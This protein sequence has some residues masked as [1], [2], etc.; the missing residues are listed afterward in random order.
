M[1]VQIS[2][3]YLNVWNYDFQPFHV[4]NFFFLYKIVYHYH[5]I[6]NILIYFSLEKLRRTLNLGNVF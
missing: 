4:D 2:E 5:T 3:T 1:A 6:R